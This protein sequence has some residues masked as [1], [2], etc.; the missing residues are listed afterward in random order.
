MTMS[1]HDEPEHTVELADVKRGTVRVTARD[2]RVG[3]VVFDVSGGE[4]AVSRV[5]HFK[6]TTRIVRDDRATTTLPS[7]ATITV[8]R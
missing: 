5:V 1:K 8:K 4:H 7:A 6:R 3:D 2:V